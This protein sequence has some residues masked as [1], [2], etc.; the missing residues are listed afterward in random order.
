MPRKDW[1][2]IDAKTQAVRAL[3]WGAT[4]AAVLALSCGSKGAVAVTATVY[5]PDLGVDASSALAARLMGSFRLHLELG[6]YA[7]SG[8]DV[9]IAQGNFALVDAASQ[10]TLVLLKFTTMPAAPYHLDPGGMIDITFTIAD[11]AEAP[12][13]LLTKEEEGA[14]CAARAAVQVGGSLSDGSGSVPVGSMAFALRC[15]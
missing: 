9:S 4:L 12:G 14:A 8:T 6:Q 11:R 10:T 1:P 13:Q 5:G 15:P 2:T 3:G 7:S